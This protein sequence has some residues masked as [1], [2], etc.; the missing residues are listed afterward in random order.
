M[1]TSDLYAGDYP[2]CVDCDL[3]IIT[4]GR[5]RNIGES[6]LNLT[7]DNVGIMKNVV[8]SIQKYYTVSPQT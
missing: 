4:A 5:G 2:D 6:R 1:G 8:T 7:N 3:I